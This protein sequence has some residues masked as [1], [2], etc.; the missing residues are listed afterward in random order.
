MNAMRVAVALVLGLTAASAAA[1]SRA[2]PAA[3][4]AGTAVAVTAVPVAAQ[5]LAD[6]LETGGSVRARLVA[7]VVSRIMAEVQSVDVV[8]GQRVRSGQTVIRLDARELQANQLRAAAAEAAARNGLVVADADRQAA[9]AALTL[10]RVTHQRLADLRSRNS[11]TQ[12]EL[13]E[14]VANLR[15]TESRLRA[16][17]ARIAE[18]TSALDAAAAATRVASVMLSYASLQAP[19]DGVVTEKRVDPGNMASPGQP[20]LTIEDT[21]RFTLEVRLDESR[22]ALVRLGQNV[23]VI[24]DSPAAGSPAGAGT[25]AAGVTGRVTEISR[26]LDAGAHDFLVKIELPASAAGLRTGM[27]GRALLTGSSHRGIAVPSSALVRRGQLSYVFVAGTDG[28]AHLRMVNAGDALGDRVEI[29]AGLA[30]G[31]RVIIEP[32][33]LLT[34]GTPVTVTGGGAARQPE[35]GR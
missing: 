20:L 15:A 33:T 12:N 9:D 10:A 29:R 14:A 7:T 27:Y 26:V 23:S 30:A 25:P 35:A 18:A 2:E 8:P 5:E 21:Q 3:K 11:A 22:A 4:P 32:P 19:F 13:D 17:D 16:A 24:L 6:T 1:C 28:R 34:D 31:D